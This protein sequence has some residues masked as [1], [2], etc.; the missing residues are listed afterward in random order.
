MVSDFRVIVATRRSGMPSRSSYWCVAE[1]TKDGKLNPISPVFD[2]MA[3]A[4]RRS[5]LLAKE[6]HQGKNLQVTKASYPV[7]SRKPPRQKKNR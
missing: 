7:D 4:E 6:E 1:I 2:Y 3:D 5:E